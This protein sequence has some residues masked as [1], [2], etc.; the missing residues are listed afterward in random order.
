[1]PDKAYIVHKNEKA[2]DMLR[3]QFLCVV[4]SAF[5]FFW[6]ITVPLGVAINA[7]YFIVVLISFWVKQKAFTVTVSIFCS[8]LTIMAVFFQPTVPDMWKVLFNRCIGLGVI[9][10]TA[11]LGIQ[12]KTSEEHR[13]KA[14]REREI[15]LNETKILRGMIPI[16]SACKKIRDSEGA[17]TQME[18]YIRN[19][20]EADF[21]HGICPECAKRLYPELKL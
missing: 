8:I 6:D 3:L 5:I 15:A 19:H 21:S 2:W 14:A 13:E 12:W 11:G 20:S 16:C 17:W 1:M 4:L 7:L 18:L 10:V 9:W